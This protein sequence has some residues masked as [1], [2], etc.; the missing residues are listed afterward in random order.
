MDLKVK[1]SVIFI[2]ITVKNTEDLYTESSG[3]QPSSY[4]VSAHF[5][6][7]FNVM[8]FTVVFF[9]CFVLFFQ[10]S[11]SFAIPGIYKEGALTFFFNLT[12]LKLIQTSRGL[13][14]EFKKKKKSNNI[15]SSKEIAVLVKGW[16]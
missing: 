6:G 11:D 10:F 14:K 16:Y 8:E 15:S 13:K 3:F 12:V 1:L 4:I 7:M 5:G 9:C 2:R